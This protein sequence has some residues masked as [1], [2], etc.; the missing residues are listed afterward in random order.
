MVAALAGAFP[1]GLQ[2]WVGHGVEREREV[3]PPL[4]DAF[5]CDA[6]WAGGGGAWE[7]ERS[8]DL[9]AVEDTAGGSN[10]GSHVVVRH[11]P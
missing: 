2:R 5:Y 10:S 8:A 1:P 7:A 9:A 3:R 11:F 4:V 6:G